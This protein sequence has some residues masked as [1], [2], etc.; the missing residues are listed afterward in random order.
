MDFQ[1]R[2]DR[3]PQ[4]RM[5]LRAERAEYLRLVEKGYGNKASSQMVG[6]HERTGREWRNGR[7]D[8]KRRVLPARNERAA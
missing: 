5:K 3:K 6:V 2:P 1:I 4:G 8:P 7:D